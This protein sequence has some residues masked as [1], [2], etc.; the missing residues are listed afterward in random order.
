MVAVVTMLTALATGMLFGV[1][2]AVHASRADA[3]SSLKQAGERGGTSAVRALGRSTLVV[4]EVALTLVLLAGAGLLLNS[5]LRLQRVE[6]GLTP[7]HATVVG[8]V[9]PQSR[10]PTSG[11]AGWRVSAADRSLV[12]PW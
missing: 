3:Q 6:S 5:L 7:D 2:P 9:V 8:L 11:L 4:V 12:A 10:Y 1:M